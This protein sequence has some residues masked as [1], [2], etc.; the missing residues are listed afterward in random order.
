MPLLRDQLTKK[1]MTSFATFISV[2]KTIAEVVSL[3]MQNAR[4]KRLL[5]Y[6]DKHALS[7]PALNQEQSYSL[8]GEQIKTVPKL[9][10]D[11]DVKPYVMISMDNFVPA[12]NQTD[13]RSA[14]LEIDILC[15]YDHWQLDDFKLRPYAIAGEID[16]MVNN[17]SLDSRVADFIGAK[18][19][20]LNETLGGVM[21]Y[22]N[23]ETFFDDKELQVASKE[24]TYNPG[25]LNG[26]LR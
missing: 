8:L 16:G 19:L 9:K 13:F 1:A 18:R 5:Y 10:V 15:S 11:P 23:L 24:K 2:E 7:L 12:P 17:T 6:T 14:T 4:L 26:Q 3:C 22:Y 20:V 21:L 25:A